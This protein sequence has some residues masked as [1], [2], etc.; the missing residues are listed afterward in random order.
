[1]S[2]M[3]GTAQVGTATET[4]G[5]TVRLRNAIEFLRRRALRLRREGV[6]WGWADTA[7]DLESAANILE[8]GDDTELAKERCA[9]AQYE[10]ADQYGSSDQVGVADA[11][12]WCVSVEYRRVPSS[13]GGESATSPTK[14]DDRDAQAWYAGPGARI[15]DAHMNG[16]HSENSENS[17]TC[18]GCVYQQGLRTRTILE[19]PLC[20]RHGVPITA[21]TVCSEYESSVR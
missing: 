19:P 7:D 9:A 10:M 16:E 8:S 17:K 21:R 20:R 6:R 11:G 12:D 3:A 4:G 18:A 1:M 5:E 14:D 15:L 13:D 2:D